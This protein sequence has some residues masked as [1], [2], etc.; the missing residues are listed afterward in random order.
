MI[1]NQTHI[2]GKDG[3][4]VHNPKKTGHVFPRSGRA[5]N[6]E[7]VLQC[8]N[9]GEEPFGSDKELFVGHLQRGY[10]FQHHDEDTDNDHPEQD[11]IKIFSSPG[12]GAKNCDEYELLQIHLFQSYKKKDRPV[13][14][15]FLSNFRFRP[16]SGLIASTGQTSAQAPQSVHSSGS[17][18]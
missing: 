15:V 18:I 4:Q 12:I 3:Q 6:S 14:A 11:H 16:Y 17:I 9:N 2:G 7:Q 8:K 10:T 1:K 13:E 5:I